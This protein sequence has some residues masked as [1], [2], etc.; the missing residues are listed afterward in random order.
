MAGVIKICGK[1]TS[2]Y[3]GDNR[4]TVNMFMFTFGL[5]NVYEIDCHREMS[6]YVRLH[7]KVVNWAEMYSAEIS[8]EVHMSEM[9]SDFQICSTEMGNAVENN[10]SKVFS[11]DKKY[12]PKMLSMLD[13]L[14]GETSEPS[15]TSVL[16][17]REV[18]LIF[19]HVW[20]RP[21]IWKVR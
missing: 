10:M 19:R 16:V 13:N 6:V 11:H 5:H 4:E 2:I 3:L 8:E 14:T 20:P 15:V 18:V 7:H 21:G 12:L 17:N 1:Q 9:S